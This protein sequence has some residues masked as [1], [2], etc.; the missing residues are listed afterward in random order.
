[1][2]VKIR[3]VIFDLDETKAMHIRC[4]RRLQLSFSFQ[5][6]NSQLQD[7]DEYNTLD[8]GLINT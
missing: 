6:G 3:T 1:M 7:R 5:C 8:S 2:K 4:K